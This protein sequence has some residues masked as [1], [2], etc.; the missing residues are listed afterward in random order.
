MSGRL[1]GA[2]VGY[3][4]I[5]SNGHVPT[6]LKD[7]GAGIGAVADGS[8]ARRAQ[9][10]RDIPGVRVYPDHV[11]LL[12]AEA[13]RLDFL[14]IATPPCDHAAIA[15]AALDEGLH[16]LCEKPL[17]T[18]VEDAHGMLE[19]AAAAKR[20]IF[21]CH[22]Y[23]HAPVVKAVRKIL[24]RGDIGP[25]HLVTLQTFR[26]THA[27][28]VQAWRPDWRRERAVSGG[29]VAMDHGSH[30]FYLAFEWMKAYP[31]DERAT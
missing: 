28:G 20:V 15:H 9:A 2:L 26:N 11:S 8:E 12:K 29:G 31:T 4:F 30:T 18:S 13:A 1:N 16:V 22:N 21:P 5:G 27:K 17:A 24:D 10:L 23:K 19:H 7:A 6:Y 25:V 14:D 3:G